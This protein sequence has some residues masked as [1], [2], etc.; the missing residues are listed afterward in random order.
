M[1]NPA[2]TE[3]D[4]AHF[5]R[6]TKY[7]VRDHAG[8]ITTFLRNYVKFDPESKPLV[9]TILSTQEVLV[10]QLKSRGVKS[11]FPPTES[12]PLNRTALIGWV[13]MFATNDPG[14]CVPYCQQ[15]DRALVPFFQANEAAYEAFRLYLK[16]RVEK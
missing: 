6:R 8:M 7:L 9:D 11:E 2:L 5:Q 15:K 3:D 14:T 13:K 10:E 4:T 12:H 1:P 16:D